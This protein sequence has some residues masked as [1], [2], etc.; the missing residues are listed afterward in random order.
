MA[1]TTVLGAANGVTELTDGLHGI[2]WTTNLIG[3]LIIDDINADVAA[4]KTTDGG[5]TWG[6]G[7]AVE[8]GE[9]RHLGCWFDRQTVGNTGTKVHC[10]WIDSLDDEVKYAA[11]DIAA[12]TWSAVKTVATSVA[13]NDI[14]LIHN[15]VAI[16]VARS[17]RIVLGWSNS[18]T[19]V[20]SAESTD[21]GANFAAITSIFEA[22]SPADHA[23][24]APCNTGDNADAAFIYW[25][26]SAD[27]LS[28]KVHDD[29]ADTV[30][31]T[32][33]STGM[34]DSQSYMSQMSVT[35]RLSDGHALVAAWNTSDQVTSDLKTWDITIDSVSAP[36]ITA[37]ADV[38]TDQAES[39]SAAI[40]VN[41]Q[42]DDVYVAYA[43]GTAAS[44]LVAVFYKKSTD[45]M[46]TWGLQTAMQEDAE[47]DHRMVRVGAMGIN[48]GGRFQPVWFDDDDI[49]IFSNLT[50]DIEFAPIA[51]GKGSG[52]KGK[53][54]SGPGQPP[55]K[56]LRTSV[57]KWRWEGRGW[58]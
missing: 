49:D 50:N 53:G 13:P 3:A 28:V 26:S 2:Y 11:F 29:S 30:T 5:A 57:G 33:I 44:S 39:T 8:A 22:S 21:S 54:G 34:V 51:G 17:G 7:V 42:S 46:A 15:G 32:S 52:G 37:T 36:T 12:G 9:N 38:L 45:D 6:A 48:Q 35:T 1:D 55:K 27:E 41:N 24:G 10:V 14:D 47:D 19:A 23:R 20:G 43:T 25:D 16:T 4:M 18:L 40:F 56:A 31:E 58:R